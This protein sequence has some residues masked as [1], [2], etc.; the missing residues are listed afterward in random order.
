[1]EKQRSSFTFLSILIGLLVSF[2]LTSSVW[3]A[4]QGQIEPPQ[5]N[6]SSI[7]VVSDYFS[8]Q[9]L[10][11]DDGTHLEGYFINGPTQPLAEYQIE[12]DAS[13]TDVAPQ[14]TLANFPSY[15]WVFGCSAV[16]SAM[17][18]AWYDRG[19]FPDMYTGPTDGGLMPLTDTCWP[20]WTEGE[21]IFPSN[22]LVASRNGVDGHNSKG[23][24]EDYWT[25]YGTNT[26]DPYIVGSWPQ[27]TWGTAIG[28]FMK[29]SQSAYGNADGST[30]FYNYAT[31][32]DK[33]FCSTMYTAGVADTD[34]TY[35]RKRFYEARGYLVTDCYNQRTDNN[36][37]GFTLAHFKAEIDAGHPVLINLAGH[38]IVGYGYNGST[39]YIRNTWD[40]N[41][42]TV[43]TMPWG[44]SY[45]GMKMVS[46]SVVHPL[47][48]HWSNQQYLPFVKK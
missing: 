17:I 11:I 18:A 9:Q 25:R 34:G 29:T 2:S 6:N 15:S 46:V 39:V 33:L 32:A 28:D 7:E 22:P 38:S 36:S 1:M 40:S 13:I 42:G 30:L 19:S 8:I 41:P 14:G 26:T 44:G 21:Q 16:S 24:V 31:S 20:S 12:H 5:N 37:G 3:A 4:N 35:G 48:I 45:N 10:T 43:Y 27:H 47:K 23:S